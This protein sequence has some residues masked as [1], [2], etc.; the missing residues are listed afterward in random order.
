[1][2]GSSMRAITEEFLIF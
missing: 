2:S 1:M